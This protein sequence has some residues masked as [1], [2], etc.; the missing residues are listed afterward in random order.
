[1]QELTA[2]LLEIPTTPPKHRKFSQALE[3]CKAMESRVV[4]ALPLPGASSSSS[5]LRGCSPSL[6]FPKILIPECPRQS[7]ASFLC[8][9]STPPHPPQKTQVLSQ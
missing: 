4:A 9:L 6:L 3:D 5:P 2:E 1:M 7:Q 8:C